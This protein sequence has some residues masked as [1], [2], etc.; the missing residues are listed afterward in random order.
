MGVPTVPVITQ[1]FRELVTS[2]AY[3]KGIPNMRMVYTPH[4]VTDRPPDICR[5]YIE[6]KDPVSGKPM[7]DVI[8]TGLTQPISAEDKQTGMIP[9]PPRSRLMEPMTAAKLEQYFHDN[10]YTD[11][12]P[13][14]LPTQERVAAM[15]KA[16]SHKPDEIAGHMRPSD[17]HE[18]W[19]YTVE[20][21]AANAVMAGAKPEYFPAILA[22][23][24]TGVTSLFSS[25]ASFA[26]MAVLNGPVIKELGMNS[27]IGAMGPFN[28][29]NATIGRAWTLI[30]KNLGGSGKLGETYLGSQGNPLS[31]SNICFP[32][33]EEGLPEGWSRVSVQKGFKPSESVVSLFSGW[34][35]SDIAWFSSMPIHQVIRGWLE[36][37]F[38]TSVSQATLILD[39]IV[40]KDI[41]AA[42]FQSK[43]AYAEYLVK[44][45]GTPTWLYWQNHEAQLKQAKEGVEPYSGYLKL[46]E[47]GVVPEPRFGRGRGTNRSGIEIIVTGGS[48]NAYWFGGDFSHVASASIDKWR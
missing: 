4:P 14:V 10:G 13:I 18:A 25:T 47:N 26:R 22:V 48:T 21:V 6:G 43:E 30:S 12:F 46:G 34:S 17:P 20:M 38:S 28:H 1:S 2:I 24:S 33:A 3:K 16:T 19:E 36:H 31:Y 8:L 41:A 42:G 11:G 39:P 45:T 44:N 15:L 5:K 37:F 35:L 32:E 23:S 7:L 40:A 9:R 29:A 27:G